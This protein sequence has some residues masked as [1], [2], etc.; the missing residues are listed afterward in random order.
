MENAVAEI[1]IKNDQQRRNEKRFL[2]FAAACAFVTMFTT[3]AIHQIHLP[4]G[5]F[6]DSVHLYKSEAYLWLNWIILFHCLM[7]LLSMLGVAL[8]IEK[9]SRALA[10]VGFL[11]LALFVF[12]EWERTLGNLWHLNGLRKTYVATKDLD[13]LQFLRYEMQYRLYQSNV[14]FLLFTIGFTLGNACYGVAL[15]TSK[16]RDRW[17]G[18]SLLFWACCT[19]LAFAID[20]HPAKWMSSI[21]EAC[22]KFYQP[23]IRFVIGYWLLKK[24]RAM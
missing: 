24:A 4:A 2:Y 15:I 10:L 1:E 13:T 21:V 8:V 12:S 9:I 7:V 5:S 6:E 20:F 22:N 17:L 3:I 18:L 11:L 19:S 16:T 14:H 23:I